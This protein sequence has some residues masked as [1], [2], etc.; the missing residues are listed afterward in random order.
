MARTETPETPLGTPCPD[1]ALPDPSGRVRPLDELRGPNGLVVAFICN[2]C[3]YVIAMAPRLAADLAALE[4]D[5]VGS[6]CVMP[7]DWTSHPADAPDKM[8]AFA[9]ENGLEA[10]YLVDETQEVARAFGAVCTPDLFGYG[11]DMTLRYRGRIDDALRG[12]T[13]A[14]IADRRPELLDAMRTIARGGTVTDQTPSIG[15]SIKWR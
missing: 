3:P 5:G 11:P 2:H 14:E 9:A 8:G 4:A 7:N 13:D 12:A 15:C 1:F 6:V 10:P